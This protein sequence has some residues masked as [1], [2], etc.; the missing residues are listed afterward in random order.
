MEYYF[1]SQR[2]LKIFNHET[3]GDFSDL[4]YDLGESICTLVQVLP[5]FRSTISKAELIYYQGKSTSCLTR[6]SGIPELENRVK[7]LSY[8]LSRHKTEFSQIVTL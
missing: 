7:K 3:A 5:Q 8:G 6:R 1:Y 4:F 2:Y